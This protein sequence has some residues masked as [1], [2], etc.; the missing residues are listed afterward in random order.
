MA[1]TPKPVVSDAEAREFHRAVSMS[2][3]SLTSATKFA[4]SAFLLARVPERMG[5]HA[6]C[7]AIGISFAHERGFNACIDQVMK[8]RG[9]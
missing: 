1:D 7:K 5:E 4:L 9:G 8:G 3:L 6:E 2:D